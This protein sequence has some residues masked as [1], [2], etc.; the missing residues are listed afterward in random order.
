MLTT[1]FVWETYV[2]CAAGPFV[3]YNLRDPPRTIVLLVDGP[4]DSHITVYVSAL[5][6]IQ[7]PSSFSRKVHLLVN[8]ALFSVRFTFKFDFS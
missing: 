5:I 8:C 6:K 4:I 2:Q 7:A 1:S 3:V